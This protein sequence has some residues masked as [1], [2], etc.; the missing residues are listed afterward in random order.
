[1]PR[2][3]TIKQGAEVVVPVLPSLCQDQPLRIFFP[4]YLGLVHIMQEEFENVVLFFSTIRPS[5]LTN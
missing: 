5:V 1:M 3:T 4:A 2:Q